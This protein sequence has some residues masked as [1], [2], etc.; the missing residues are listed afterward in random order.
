[1]DSAEAIIMRVEHLLLI[2]KQ[3]GSSWV[4]Q[5]KNPYY[6]EF[7]RYSKPVRENRILFCRTKEVAV[8]ENDENAVDI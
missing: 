5:R 1:M 2:S 6:E 3:Y 7:W 4:T 8:K